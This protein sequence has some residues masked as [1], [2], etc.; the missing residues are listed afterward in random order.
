MAG[1][2]RPGAGRPKGAGAVTVGREAH[3]ADNPLAYLLAVMRD[4]AAEPSRRDRAAIA[5]LPYMHAK[6]AP[7]GAKAAAQ[8]RAIES[9]EAADWAKLLS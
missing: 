1:G 3:A 6:P 8:R 9:G 5:V 4:E 7:E 2:Y